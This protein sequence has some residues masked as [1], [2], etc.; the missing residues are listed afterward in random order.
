MYIHNVRK[1]NEKPSLYWI[2][3]VQIKNHEQLT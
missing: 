2:N 1:K 3:K